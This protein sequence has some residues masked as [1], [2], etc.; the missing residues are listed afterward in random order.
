MVFL[1]RLVSLLCCQETLVDTRTKVHKGNFAEI[2]FL[3]SQWETQRKKKNARKKKYATKDH[4]FASFSSHSSGLIFI[5]GDF[6]WQRH[7]IKIRA[8]ITS[9]CVCH[10]HYHCF[11][12]WWCISSIFGMASR[13]KC[14]SR[15]SVCCVCV[16]G[17]RTH[18][19]NITLKNRD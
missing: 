17:A 15:F 7:A 5:K 19:C 11:C 16:A 14:H 1:L 4:D 9:G 2:F 13:A 6:I 8:S 18:C 10:C 12:C 3:P